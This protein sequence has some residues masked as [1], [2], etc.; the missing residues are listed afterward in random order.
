LGDDER[1]A[2]QIDAVVLDLLPDQS[3]EGL[4]E[5]GWLVA[6]H[7]SM[8]TGMCDTALWPESA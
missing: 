8:V 2:H 7:A 6:R 3:G 4:R 5:R 1:G